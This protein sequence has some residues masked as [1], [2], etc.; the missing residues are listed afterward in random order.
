M[1]IEITESHYKALAEAAKNIPQSL[2]AK[3]SVSKNGNETIVVECHQG[4]LMRS[5]GD[6][7]EMI[8]AIVHA[9][10]LAREIYYNAEIIRLQEERD[11]S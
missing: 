6:G 9:A 3:Q 7:H 2:S 4:Q 5:G 10:N 1:R 11:F 8:V